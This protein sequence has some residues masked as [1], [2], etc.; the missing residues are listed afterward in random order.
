MDNQLEDGANAIRTNV[1]G[2]RK[3]QLIGMG[4]LDDRLFFIYTPIKPKSRLSS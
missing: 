1:N 4:F 3:W 2:L